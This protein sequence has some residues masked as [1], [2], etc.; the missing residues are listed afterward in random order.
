ME[1]RRTPRAVPRDDRRRGRHLRG[2][3]GPRAAR[4]SRRRAGD[5]VGER[6]AR[7][8]RS[9]ARPPG[10]LGARRLRGRRPRSPHR[11]PPRASPATTSCGPRDR[12]RAASP[13]APTIGL[14]LV[15]ISPR[16]PDQ[17]QA[18]RDWADF[19][20][21]RH[22]AAAG[23][24]GYC[25]DHAVR[26]RGRRRSPVPAP[27]RDRPRRPRG[28][29]PVDDAARR[30]ALRRLQHRRSTGPGPTPPSCGSCT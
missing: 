2:G 3:A 20:H 25:D 15:L 9:P 11:T 18:L 30:P 14:S 23:V 4:R 16:E 22:I 17:A 13:A 7:P 6:R 8:H 29:V 24:P 27:L 5:L 19:V 10:V 12:A 28:G 21:I 26:A 1:D